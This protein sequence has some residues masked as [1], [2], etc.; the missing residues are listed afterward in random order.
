M[1]D[2]NFDDDAGHETRERRYVK[3]ESRGGSGR[4]SK[5]RSTKWRDI[6][7]LKEQRQLERQLE[8]VFFQ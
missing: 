7:Q 5:P 1:E 8:D 4:A 3:T 2:L 6:E